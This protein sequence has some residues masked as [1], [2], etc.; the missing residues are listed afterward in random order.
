MHYRSTNIVILNGR[1]GQDAQVKQIADNRFMVTFSLAT[2][3]SVRDA[4]GGW[5]H[6]TLWHSCIL[7]G[8]R[9]DRLADR[10]LK[11]AL[12]SIQGAISYRDIDQ[13]GR[14]VRY[15]D[16]VVDDVQILQDAQKKQAAPA[17]NADARPAPEPEPAPMDA[18]QAGPDPDEI[19]DF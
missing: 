5:T 17:Q 2:S 11:G 13:D 18:A 19:P 14:K 15:T 8:S 12:V 1:I 6:P 3:S 9:A 16:I 10:L 7:F 4:N